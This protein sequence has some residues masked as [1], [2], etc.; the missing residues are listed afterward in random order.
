MRRFEIVK[1]DFRKHLD[2]EI[3]LPKRATIYS[4]GYDF[5]SP[6]KLVIKPKETVKIFT[7]IKAKM[8]DYEVLTLHIRSSIGIKKNLMLANCTGIVD[9]DYYSNPD[10]DGNI[11]IA[12]YNYGIK[13]EI[14]EKNERVMQG[15][16]TNFNITTDDNEKILLKQRNGGVGSTGKK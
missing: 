1:N 13:I 12:L 9:S 8:F 5:C 4:A 15:I 2:S 6:E 14:I 10:N 7:D 16:F 3:I 11:I